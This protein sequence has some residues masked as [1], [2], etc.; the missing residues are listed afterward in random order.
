MSKVEWKELGKFAHKETQRNKLRLDYP[1]YSITQGGLV[2]TRDFFKEKTNVTSKDTST[3][4]VVHKHWFV[5]SPSRIDVGSINYLRVEGPVIVSPI[6]VVFSINADECTPE[7]LYYFLTSHMGMKQIMNNREGVEG[8]GRKNLPFERFASIKVP[9]PSPDEQDRIV[10]QL[11]TFTTL[12]AKLE[13]E[14]T[15]RQKQYEFYRE[16]LLN[17]DGDEEVEWKTLGEL[18]A[19]VE[20][21]QWKKESPLNLFQ[22]IDLSST[23]IGGNSITCTLE[24]NSEN[25]PSRALQIV[26]AGDI[27]F[28]TTR[29]TLMRL[30]LVN[31]DYDNQICS[32][33]YCVIRITNKLG[34]VAK[35][36]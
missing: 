19:K 3:Y 11:D 30:V 34:A 31:A 6:D 14:L 12:I 8:M 15:L 22:Y 35:S 20:K 25:A 33:G 2:P 16:E 27:L 7:Y 24:I 32:T 5:Y 26:K 9:I 21:M 23:E 29:P 28:G 18:C 4:F 17:F 1:A 36:D 10:E 13:S